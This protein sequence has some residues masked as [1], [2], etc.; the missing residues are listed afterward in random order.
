M[1]RGTVRKMT[2][3]GVG[4]RWAAL[5]LLSALPFVGARLLWPEATAI[6]FLPRPVVVGL[7][8]GLLVAGVPLCGA[9]VVRLVRG[10]PRGEL[11]TSGPYALC[12]HPIYASW[13]VFNVPAIALL[14][15]NWAGLLS[16]IPMYVALRI[17]VRKEERWLEETFGDAY[18]TYRDRVNA[19]LP[20]P[21]FWRRGGRSTSGAAG[22]VA[23]QPADGSRS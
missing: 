11:F 20:I 7:A 2:R 14:A 17:L 15:D 12:R 19:V 5:S 22:Q 3:G 4:P 8:I 6:T 18:R 16:T 13:I 9:A 23:D 10:F 21:K 1:P